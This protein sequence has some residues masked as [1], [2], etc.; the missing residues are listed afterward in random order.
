MGAVLFSGQLKGH[1]RMLACA[2]AATREGKHYAGPE[3]SL[4]V[5]GPSSQ[6]FPMAPLA[7]VLHDAADK[8]DHSDCQ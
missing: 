3:A 8:E 7:Q 5:R 1:C 2:R 4:G 6:V